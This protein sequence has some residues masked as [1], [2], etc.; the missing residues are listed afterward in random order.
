MEN[1]SF[2]KHKKSVDSTCLVWIKYTESV[3]FYLYLSNQASLTLR[4]KQSDQSLNDL[5]YKKWEKLK[6]CLLWRSH[7]LQ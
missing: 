1:N 6:T 5:K 7:V 3:S 2:F 4:I